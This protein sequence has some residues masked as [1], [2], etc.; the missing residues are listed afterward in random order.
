MME[1]MMRPMMISMTAAKSLPLVIAT[2]TA[3]RCP[4][5]DPQ[6]GGQVSGT[7]TLEG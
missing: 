5:E 1:K 2:A 4:M 3:R 6:G 7:P